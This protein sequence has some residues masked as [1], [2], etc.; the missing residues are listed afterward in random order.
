MAEQ[1]IPA[2]GFSEG[3]FQVAGRG[4]HRLKARQCVWG[5]GVGWGLLPGSPYGHWSPRVLNRS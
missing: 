3:H 4:C 1:V 5:G 2:Q